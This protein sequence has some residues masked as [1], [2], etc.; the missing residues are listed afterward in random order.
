MGTAFTDCGGSQSQF[1]APGTVRQTVT[2]S[3]RS[4]PPAGSPKY[5]VLASFNGIDGKNPYAGL[6]DVKGTL[7]GTTSGGYGVSNALG[8]VFSIDPTTGT[9]KVLYNFHADPDGN[10]P[11]AGL[12]NVSGKLY[13]T[14]AHGGTYGYGTIFSV[15][16]AGKEN[17]VYSFGGNSDGEV[18]MAALI[19]VSGLLYGTTF[20]GGSYNQGTIFSVT[21]QGNETVLHRFVG[22]PH[23]GAWPQAGLFYAKGMLYGTTTAGGTVQYGSFG[24]GTVFSITPGGTESLLYSFRGNKH[25][26]NPRAA[27][28]KVS[29]ALFGTTMQGGKYGCGTVFS[30]TKDG[31]KKTLHSFGHGPDGC[32]PYAGLIDVKGILYGTTGHGGAYYDGHDGGGTVFSMS[33]TGIE[34]V[35]HS[36][37]SGSDG[38]DPLAGVTNLN[39]TLYG[40]TN[41]GGAY[42]DGTVFA[43]TP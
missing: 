8:N 36:F 22:Y 25:G 42:G 17:V 34:T 31:T 19:E 29:G 4:T 11:E 35:L 40:T 13:G 33:P 43:L 5:R 15:T 3:M 21:T 7:Y 28:T 27:L 32:F 18:P 6:V 14:T 10:D 20:E 23:D 12:V 16:L 38:T 26:S 39:G 30:V 1:G 41:N 2:K 37:G 9:E 24:A